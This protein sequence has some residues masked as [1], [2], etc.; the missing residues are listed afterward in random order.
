[1][2]GAWG[3][4]DGDIELTELRLNE[5]VDHLPRPPSLASDAGAFAL[6]IVG[7]AMWPRFRPGRRVAVSPKAPVAI[8]DDVV[9]SLAAEQE[10]GR[11]A[12]L[13]KEL[14]RRTAAYL[15]LRQFNPEATFRVDAR[16]VSAI[17][18]VMGELF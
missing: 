9:V 1:M 7:D 16:D 3:P 6:T 18:K 14:V 2:A 13:I 8:G 12:A 10:T 11:T 5:I 15:E 4:A 17:H